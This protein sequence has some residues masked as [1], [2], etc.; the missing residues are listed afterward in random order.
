MTKISASSFAE[1]K[2]VE[3]EIFCRNFDFYYCVVATLLEGQIFKTSFASCG[4][5][6]HNCCRSNCR[7]IYWRVHDSRW[8]GDIV[9]DISYSGDMG[10]SQTLW[11][12]SLEKD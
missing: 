7:G 4:G 9:F 8:F 6:C 2:K 3:L 1:Q 12:S 10:H 5:E 11:K